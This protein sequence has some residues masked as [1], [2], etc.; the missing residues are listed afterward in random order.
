MIQ[1]D[2]GTAICKWDRVA[3]FAKNLLEPVEDLYPIR[4]RVFQTPNEQQLEQIG[5][6]EL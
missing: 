4:Y 2:D 5:R 1:V 3:R 6:V